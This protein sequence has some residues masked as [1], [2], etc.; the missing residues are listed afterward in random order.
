MIPSEIDDLNNEMRMAP[1]KAREP[2][3]SLSTSNHILHNQHP[4]PN[5]K[6]SISTTSISRIDLNAKAH[7]TVP[8]TTHGILCHVRLQEVLELEKCVLQDLVV[9]HSPVAIG[10]VDFEDVSV[11]S[12]SALDGLDG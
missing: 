3:K 12:G 10:E 8:D 7:A 11:D 5:I 4:Q 2:P 6:H 9:V 1:W